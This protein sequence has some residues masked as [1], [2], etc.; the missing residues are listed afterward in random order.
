MVLERQFFSV[1]EAAEALCDT[2]A[3]KVIMPS[4]VLKEVQVHQGDAPRSNLER[5][6]QAKAIADYVAA[7]A[8]PQSL[9]S[10]RSISSVW[11]SRLDLL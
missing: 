2:A 11:K 7:N 10:Q 6:L 9:R 1:E 4:F 5:C 3:G 8:K